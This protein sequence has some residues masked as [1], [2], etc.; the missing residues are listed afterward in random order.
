MENFNAYISEIRSLKMKSVEKFMNSAHCTEYNMEY[1][2]KLENLLNLALEDL[3]SL[4]KD[5]IK[6]KLIFINRLEKDF[7]KFDAYYPQLLSHS[8]DGLLSETELFYRLVPLFEIENYDHG[9]FSEYFVIC[10]YVV[11]IS[12]HHALIQFKNKQKICCWTKF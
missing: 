8:R 5:D 6:Q 9:Y 2:E 11:I 12:K 4:S 1:P 10:L 3:N 7:S